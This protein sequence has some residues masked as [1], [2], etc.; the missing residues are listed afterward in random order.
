M[1]VASPLKDSSVSS[2]PFS[3]PNVSALLK[4][5]ILSW[6]QETGLPVA[7]SF[8]VG[9]KI[10]NLHK[11]ILNKRLNESNEIDLPP[12]F[13][14]GPETF[15]MIALLIYGS[16]TLI[17][18][19]NVVALRCAAEFL[20]MTE[21]YSSGNLCERFDLDL[22]QVVMQSWDDTLI[23]LQKCQTLLP[24][25]EDLLIVSRCIECLAFM[26]CMEILDHERRHETPVLTLE[27]LGTGNWS[28]E[29]GRE[30][31]NQ[32]LWIKDL[33]YLSPIIVFYANKWV[34]S[35]KTLQFWE[36]SGQRIGYDHKV[37]V[38]LQGVLDLL[39]MGDK[40]SRSIPVGFYLAI[41]SRSLEVGLRI[42]TR[43]KLQGQIVSLLHFSQ[44]GDF[45]FPKNGSESISSSMELATME[46]IISAYVSS[47]MESDNSLLAGNTIVAELWY[48]T[49]T[50]NCIPTKP[51][52]GSNSP[53]LDYNSRQR[54]DCSIQI[55]S[56]QK[57]YWL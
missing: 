54:A 23:V 11:W 7:V 39:L 27:A 20:E 1:E 4:I 45:L 17:D 36:N 42:D 18:P 8:R 25:S 51:C 56:K 49:Y 24:W 46:S 53:C 5:K 28:C 43:V 10:F 19:F 9:G 47:N 14:G 40:A 2:I 44:L 30:I 33:I 31:M 48:S 55:H 37:S 35:T 3:S 41:L 52:Q 21:D 26:A 16:S 38:I 6:T 57:T 13:P 34:L 29:T 32:D 15:E 12:G 50:S 22:N